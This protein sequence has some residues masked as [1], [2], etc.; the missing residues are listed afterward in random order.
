ML[1]YVRTTLK[2]PPLIEITNVYSEILEKFPERACKLEPLAT[3]KELEETQKK[4]EKNKKTLLS[5]EKW[6]KGITATLVLVTAATSYP[7]VYVSDSAKGTK[8]RN[9]FGIPV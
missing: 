9:Y 4:I 7:Y 5:Q 1:S 8:V 6:L 2:L 3:P